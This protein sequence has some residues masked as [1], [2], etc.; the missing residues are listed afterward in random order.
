MTF[1]E[2]SS[3]VPTEE[4]AI[5]Y[6]IKNRYGGTLAC[7]HCR[8]ITKVYRYRKLLKLCHCKNCKNS[9]SPFK[10]TIFE[11]SRTKL[12]QWFYAIHLLLNDRKGTSACQLQRELGVTYKTA[13][14]MLHKI[15][16]AMGNEDMAKAFTKLVE[17]DETYMGPKPR[18]GGKPSKSG[19][20]TS[21]TV[22]FG[23]KERHTGRVYAQ[24]MLPEEGKHSR[25]S[26]PKFLAIIERICKDGIIIISDDLGG[27]RILDKPM[28]KLAYGY[29]HKIVPHKLGVYSDGH[30]VHTNGIESFWAVLKKGYHGT[31]QYMSVKYLQRYLDEFCFRQNT[32]KLLSDEVFD[33]LLKRAVVCESPLKS[34]IFSMY[35]EVET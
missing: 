12:R 2:F 13:L 23:L 20:G 27:Y 35:K 31:Y 18:K 22:V 1:S 10:G 28:I 19:W 24:V 14:S 32:R 7:P 34:L 6:F 15:R 33:L 21:K 4:T 30:G 16:L 29:I 26:G 5:N 3:K 17:I 8:A 11:K 25:L 9:F